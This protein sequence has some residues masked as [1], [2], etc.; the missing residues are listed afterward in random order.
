MSRSAYSP[1][2]Y[3]IGEVARRL[4]VAVETIRMYEREGLLLIEKTESGQRV[5]TDADIHWIGCIRKFIKE[6]GLNI[7]GIRRLL[8]LIPCWEIL[9]CSYEH[10]RSRC[11]AFLHPSKPC[12]MMKDELPP[13]CR[14]KNCRECDVY[15]TA[16]RCENL[17]KLLYT[18]L[19]H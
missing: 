4:N 9:P 10:D 11:P 3:K 8:A 12:W 1:I 5:F 6:K 18:Q 17:K 16:L 15:K 7:E 14:D 2:H 13:V 19:Y